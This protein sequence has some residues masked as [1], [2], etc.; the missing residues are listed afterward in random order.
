MW[1]VCRE[2]EE[3]SV[4]KAVRY[5]TSSLSWDGIYR[6]CNDKCH[7]HFMINNSFYYSK[8]EVQKLVSLLLSYCGVMLCV[9]VWCCVLWCDV[10]CC[11]V[12]LCVVVWCCV[13][14]CVWPGVLT[15]LTPH[16][17]LDSLLLL[18]PRC[19]GS[20]QGTPRKKYRFRHHEQI[21]EKSRK[22]E[23][24]QKTW[25]KRENLVDAVLSSQKAPHDHA[26]AI[27]R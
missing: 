15:H 23:I 8:K 4:S 27:A 2:S 22:I 26:I 10:V 5:G 25:M 21:W 18:C 19:W 24:M 20:G 11:G 12:M 3:W 9:A 6:I 1:I 14:W 16:P 7:T 17:Q 13:L